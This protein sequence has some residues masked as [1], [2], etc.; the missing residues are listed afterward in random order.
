MRLLILK[1]ASKNFFFLTYLATLLLSFNYFFV[2]YI[3]S[4]YLS[5]YI[6]E[7]SVGT[8]YTLGSFFTI[9]IFFN[10]GRLLKRWGNYRLMIFFLIVEMITL[11]GL[12][13]FH[14]VSLLALS[15]LIHHTLHPLLFVFMD[16]FVEHYSTNE[17]TGMIRAVFITVVNMAAM[18]SSFLV[19]RIIGEGNFRIIY[20]LS[21]IFVIAL[22]LVV[23]INFKN[24]RD[25]NYPIIRGIALL[26]KFLREK[27]IRKIFTATIILNFFYSWLI[28]YIPI[29]LYQ[30]LN[31]TW[32]EIGMAI[33]IS[34]LPF[35]FFEI[36]LG[37][38]ADKLIG[39]KEI[40]ITGF[41]I[42][43]ISLLFI[44]SVVSL[45]IV[46][47]TILLLFARTGASFVEMASDTYF[48]KCIDEDNEELV[49]IW[50]ITAPVGY[51][52]GTIVGSVAL[53]ILPS[54][55]Q[56]FFVLAFILLIGLFYSS[57]IKD[58]L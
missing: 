19:G 2:T 15:F 22:M 39:E 26:Q 13:S 35:V 28:I 48:F 14:N 52:L 12:A 30:H 11:L 40:L 45:S 10:M 24:F 54:F 25:S 33:S 20:I 36:P 50:R 18:I 3:N 29:Y 38:L 8:L 43:I 9:I 37:K 51:V 31:F 46:V 23:R 16:I 34:L 27:N 53:I 41:I 49:G 32:P 42:M 55:Q 1:T 4:T 17:S 5:Q 44:G 57:K 6:S 47:W 56:I 21:T 58:T 7:R